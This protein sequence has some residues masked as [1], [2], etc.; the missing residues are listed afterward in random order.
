MAKYTP[1]FKNTD[2]TQFILDEYTCG[3]A[4]CIDN[5]WNFAIYAQNPDIPIYQNEYNAGYVQGK[6]QGNPMI[7][8][9]RNNSWR[10]F[11]ICLLYTSDA[12]DEL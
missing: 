10:N 4:Q 3:F 8:A 2:A 5:N 1:K 12:A 9:T 6:V 11:L 7:V